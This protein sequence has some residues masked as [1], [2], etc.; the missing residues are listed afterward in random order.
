MPSASIHINYT[1]PR[2][3]PALVGIESMRY[4]H[5]LL[6]GVIA[7]SVESNAIRMAYND[8]IT[9]F[10]D[11][12]YGGQAAGLLIAATGTGTVG[13]TIGGTAVT[14]TWATSDIVTQTALATA[15]RA[16]AVVG[17]F[18]TATNK[19]MSLTCTSVVAATTV[20][21]GNQIFTA[22]ANGSTP[23]IDGQFTVGASDTACALSLVK[24][25]NHH[26]SLCGRMRAV[27]VAGVVY[28]GLVDN[29]SPLPTDAIRY[30]S[31]S[32][33]SIGVAIPAASARIMILANVPGMIGNFIDVTA[34]GTNY[35]FATNGVAGFLGQGSGGA[36]PASTVDVVP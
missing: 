14:V 22:I 27:S 13:A 12:Y 19:L 9:P 11:G 33:I 17:L 31:A 25:I 23:S 30:A 3:F 21:I 7:G 18:A 4:F 36:L 10:A 16:S 24:A 8:S 15:I 35:S 28:I 20:N 34:S 26:P 1:R 29:R 5:K 6:E 32:T 2:G